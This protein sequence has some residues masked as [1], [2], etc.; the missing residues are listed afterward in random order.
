M[1]FAKQ[2]GLAALALLGASILTPAKADVVYQNATGMTKA[3]E[4]VASGSNWVGV[5]F[6]LTQ[7]TEITGI[8][9]LI[10][11]NASIQQLGNEF[12]A[13]VPVASGASNPG[14]DVSTSANRVNNIQ[15]AA[16]DSV[17]FSGRDILL[18]EPI[19]SVGGVQ[20]HAGLAG[21]DFATSV[22]L[23]AGTYAV[24]IGA[25]GAFGSGSGASVDI[26]LG[27]TIPANQTDT[28]FSMFSN[29]W[30][31][32]AGG[33]EIAVYGTVAAVPE[34]S[35]WAMMTLGFFGVGFIAY[36]RRNRSAALHAV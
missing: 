29:S 14:F 32:T 10:L 12:A 5:T 33:A 9:A 20:M 8:G 34:P 27:E 31:K 23:S 30:S 4:F 16:L 2:G 24:I 11:S 18:S 26:G 15:S 3:S 35:T 36:R 13:I 21:I 25:G 7:T 1:F 28:A 19:V 22:T 17:L 6:A